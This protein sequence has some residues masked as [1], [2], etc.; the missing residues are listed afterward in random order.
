MGHGPKIRQ[1]RG[2]WAWRIRNVRPSRGP[3]KAPNAVPGTGHRGN[4]AVVAFAS[5]SQCRRLVTGT[6][7]DRDRVRHQPTPAVRTAAAGRWATPPPSTDHPTRST[8][9]RHAADAMVDLVAEPDRDR[10]S[11]PLP[12]SHLGLGWVMVTWWVV[13]AFTKVVR[14]P[15][16]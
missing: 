15:Y 12:G 5:H 10:T 1:P 4:G 14:C 7:R 6:D 8:E 2:L 9:R 3:P 16:N 13:V 11:A